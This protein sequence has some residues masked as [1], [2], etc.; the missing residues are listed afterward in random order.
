M[1]AW[2]GISL[3]SVQDLHHSAQAGFQLHD[4]TFTPDTLGDPLA[5]SIKS[6]YDTLILTGM[7]WGTFSI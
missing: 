7:I 6:H 1:T 5:D 4:C 3:A 2:T